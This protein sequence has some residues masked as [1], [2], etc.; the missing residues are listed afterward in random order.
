MHDVQ[1]GLPA[2]LCFCLQSTCA[3]VL[4]SPVKKPLKEALLVV[5]DVDLAMFHLA[6]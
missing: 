4:I 3:N 6:F 5:R 2:V 1:L